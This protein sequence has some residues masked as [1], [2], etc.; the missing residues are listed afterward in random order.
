[1]K[2]AKREKACIWSIQFKIA[3]LAQIGWIRSPNAT[4]TATAASGGE[5]TTASTVFLPNSDT[6]DGVGADAHRSGTMDSGVSNS[7]MG[8]RSPTEWMEKRKWNGRR[9]MCWVAG[10]NMPLL[11]TMTINA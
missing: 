8:R 11:Q 10:A 4:A 5:T 7:M 1:M 3:G 6:G 2:R 9:A